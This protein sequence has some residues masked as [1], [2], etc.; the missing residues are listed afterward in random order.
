VLAFPIGRL[1]TSITKV[2]EEGM[3]KFLRHAGIFST[4]R[5]VGNLTPRQ[6]RALAAALRDRT[7]IYPGSWL[8]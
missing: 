6:R 8:A 4:T 7:L 3:T 1:L 5:R 2:G